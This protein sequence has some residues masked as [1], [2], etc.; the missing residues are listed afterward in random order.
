M[1]KNKLILIPGLLNDER[2]WAHQVSA[3]GDVADVEVADITREDN[4]PDLARAVLRRAPE[5][6]SLAGLSMGG[7][8]A[9]E[10]MRQE[11]N[12]IERLALVDTSA[13]ADTPE[14]TKRRKSMMELATHGKF[15]GVTP[16]LLPN[17]VH[18]DHVN[19]PGIG[20]VVLQMAENIGKDAFLR[21]QTALM[22]RVDSRPDL[23]NINCPTLIL[24]GRE[25]M[26]TPPEIHQ[27][28]ADGIGDSATLVVVEHSGHLAPLE[29]PEAVNNAFRKWMQR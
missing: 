28:M 4:I 16:M 7:Y 21:Q 2:L 18:P 13:R 9:Q 17:L 22:H 26:L 19:K 14:Q 24:C 5:K 3:L 25:D 10:I 1:P 20:D 27:E 29:Q 8:V 12:R 11:P 15:R 23:K 6:F